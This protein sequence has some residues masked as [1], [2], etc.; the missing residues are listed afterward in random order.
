[1]LARLHMTIADRILVV[2]LAAFAGVLFFVLP[3][4]VLTGGNTVEIISGED[5]VG[6]YSLDE[7]RTLNIK[8][9]LGVT[10]VEIDEGEVRVKSSPCPQKVC[11]DMGP[12]GHEGGVI[13]CVPNKVVV[14]VGGKTAG[15][16]DAVSR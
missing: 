10:V 8:G 6:V 1:M 11:M 4:M 13:A 14:K 16:L 9:P 5:V 12:R 15:G 2:T 3:G 7:D